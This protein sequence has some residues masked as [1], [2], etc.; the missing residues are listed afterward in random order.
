MQTNTAPVKAKHKAAAAEK[1]SRTGF[2]FEIPSFLSGGW[3]VFVFPV[4]NPHWTVANFS[5]M[6]FS[7]CQEATE[8]DF[9]KKF[10]I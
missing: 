10:S 6:E 1:N 8:K 7:F 3:V 4:D 9:V 2:T 5:I